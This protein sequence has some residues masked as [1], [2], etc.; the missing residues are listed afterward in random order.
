M[1][2]NNKKNILT[3]IG[4]PVLN[5][6]LKKINNLNIINNDIQYKEGI[7]EILEINKEIDFIFLSQ[8]LPGNINLNE[9]ID[10]IQEKNKKI[11][12]ILILE[13]YNE[14]L[15]KLFLK[16]GVYRI[17]YNEKI[18]INDFIKIINEDEKMEK[19]NEEIRKEIEELKKYIKNSKKPKKE[20]M[21]NNY[22]IINKK[23]IEKNKKIKNKINNKIIKKIF[24]RKKTK[25]KINYLNNKFISEKNQIISILGNNGAGKS[26]FTVMLSHEIKKYYNKI[27]IIDFDVLNNGIFNIYGIKENNNKKINLKVNNENYEVNNINKKIDLISGINLMFKNNKKINSEELKIIID[28]LSNIYNLIII[29]TTSEC[30]FDYTKEII[31]ISNYSI[32]LTE[33]NLLEIKKSKRLLDIYYNNWNIE[34]NKINIV[35]NKINLCSININ[36]LKKLFENYNLL[37][38]IKN[39]NKYNFLINMHMKNLIINFKEKEQYKKIFE[40]LI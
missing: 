20:K 18:E 15:E 28:K 19:Y 6:K 3:A 29:D 40:K 12:I 7:V 30:F 32:F 14:E 31:E 9:L 37:G 38:C 4:N 21:I 25:N 35:F 22:K 11:K 39:S 36:L 1:E 5:D 34:K 8:I 17:F 27:L 10:I 33:A 16:K 24:K 2:I 26:I 13:N 23:I